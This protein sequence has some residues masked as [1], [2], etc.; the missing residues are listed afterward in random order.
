MIP[1]RLQ[2]FLEPFW[3]DQTCDQTWTL[4][5]HIYHKNTSTN[6]RKT[7]VVRVLGIWEFEKFD[8]SE[9]RTYLAQMGKFKLWKFE[10]GKLEDS[11]L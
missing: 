4:G 7:W 10:N 3:N 9:N 1:D 5:P 6:T 8:I 11:Q 2:Y